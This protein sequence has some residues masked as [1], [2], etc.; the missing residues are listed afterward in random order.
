MSVCVFFLKI[1]RITPLGCVLGRGVTPRGRISPFGG[2]FLFSS[3][4]GL[5]WRV[6]QV[7]GA[8]NRWPTRVLRP[9]DDRWKRGVS[10]VYDYY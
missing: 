10:A 7:A 9:E 5:R 6:W 1:C 4:G 3:G 2:E 8:E